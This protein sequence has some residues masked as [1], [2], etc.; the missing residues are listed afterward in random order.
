M[1]MQD[2]GTQDKDLNEDRNNVEDL[3]GLRGTL[4]SKWGLL[5]VRKIND[6]QGF[7]AKKFENKKVRKK[8]NNKVRKD[9]E[10][11]TIIMMGG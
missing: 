1:K 7:Y 5:L 2:V 4:N 9:T 11:K 6:V 8:R 10:Y 3:V